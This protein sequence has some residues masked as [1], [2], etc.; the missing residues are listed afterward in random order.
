MEQEPILCTQVNFG[1]PGGAAVATPSYC[2]KQAP[3]IKLIVA[4]YVFDFV[5]YMVIGSFGTLSTFLADRLN[6]ARIVDP[7][8]LISRPEALERQVT[9]LSKDAMQGALR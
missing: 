5:L 9:V 7:Q 8:K 4:E 1:L 3:V 2:V 6:C